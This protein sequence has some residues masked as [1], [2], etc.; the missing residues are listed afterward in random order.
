MKKYESAFSSAATRVGTAAKKTVEEYVEKNLPDEPSV[1]VA[2]VT[3][4]KDAISGFAKGGITWN[5]KILSSHGPGTEE[6]KIG[7]DILGALSLGLPEYSVKKGFLAQA[8]RQEPGKPLDLTE[9]KRLQAQCDLMLKHSPES[10]V[11]VYAMNGFYVVPAISVAA[12]AGRED[13]H[14][15][16]PKTLSA[17]YKE[18]FMCFVGDKSITGASAAVLDD[19]LVRVAYEF[20]AI[21]TDD[22]DLFVE[23]RRGDA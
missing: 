3:R 16:H 18:H 14:T 6:A 19:L 4:I 7:A 9:W 12:C 23:D 21:A 8:K 20:T 5:A 13:L 10:F 2:L 22:K 15:L 11:F 1:S 17:F